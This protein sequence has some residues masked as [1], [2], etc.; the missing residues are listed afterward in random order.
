MGKVNSVL[1]AGFLSVCYFF[2]CAVYAGS[3]LP[4]LKVDSRLPLALSV[5]EQGKSYPLSVSSDFM[6][7]IE[8]IY[9]D[10]Y[11][12]DLSGDGVGEV[13]FRLEGESVNSCSRVLFYTGSGR[14]LSELT[15]NGRALCNFRARQGYVISSYREGAAWS[16]D[17]YSVKDGKVEAIISDNCVGCGE[18]RR[19]KYNPDGSFIRFLVSDDVDFEKRTPLTA[20]V[21]SLRAGVFSSPE[22]AQP[23]KKYLIRGDKVTLLGFDKSHSG[24]DWIEFR[25]SGSTTTEGWLKCSDLKECTEF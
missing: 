12:E 14:S 24:E 8:G 25:F 4:V 15:F 17:V 22:A 21:A 11:I 9:S 3:S 16:E 18:V 7:D 5:F 6:R 2:S 19:K 13:V 1:I 10:V 20:T 23:T